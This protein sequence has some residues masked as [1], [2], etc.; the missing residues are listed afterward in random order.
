MLS[1][2]SSKIEKLYKNYH[3]PS[4]QSLYSEII[5]T[6]NSVIQVGNWRRRLE[7]DP[8]V[9]D[10]ATLNALLVDPAISG[11]MIITILPEALMPSGHHLPEVVPPGMAALKI[12]FKS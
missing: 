5:F 10:S 7:G 4:V 2:C 1:P 9:D 8:F 3:L 6:D 11:P 12:E